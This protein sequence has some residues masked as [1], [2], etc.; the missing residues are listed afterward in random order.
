MILD[1]PTQQVH[2]LVLDE[3][4]GVLY[5]ATDFGIAL[6]DVAGLPGVLRVERSH[7][8]FNSN[9][10]SV[11]RDIAVSFAHDLTDTSASFTVMPAFDRATGR[12]IDAHVDRP[13][14]PPAPMTDGRFIYV[15]ARGI[16]S[17]ET[18][19]RGPDRS[20]GSG[21]RFDRRGD[22][23]LVAARRVGCLPG[24]VAS[25]GSLCIDCGDRRIVSQRRRFNSRRHQF[26]G[27]AHDLEGWHV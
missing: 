24:R 15:R 13:A 1:I 4:S 25:E 8:W 26:I 14:G 10:V 21:R 5:G 19:E 20:M 6:W 12:I 2:Q 27:R 3:V 16:A 9:A 11:N 7:L 23:L 17:P 18:E 22:G